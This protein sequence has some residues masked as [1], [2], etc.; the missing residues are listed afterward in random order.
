MMGA[1]HQPSVRMRCSLRPLLDDFDPAFVDAD[2]GPAAQSQFCRTRT[3]F[4]GNLVP[5]EGY[6]LHSLSRHIGP[7]W[8]H[9]FLFLLTRYFVLFMRSVCDSLF[10]TL[11]DHAPSYRHW[12]DTLAHVCFP[13]S[14]RWAADDALAALV[15]LSADSSALI[16]N[17]VIKGPSYV[18]AVRRAGR[19]FRLTC[20]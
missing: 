6:R 2:L 20:T 3:R 16:A 10:F 7:A 1:F 12:L 11:A 5:T 4:V 15:K 19:S 14:R 18:V 17:D 9:H 8:P 13:A